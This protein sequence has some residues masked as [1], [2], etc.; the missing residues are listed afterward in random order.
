VREVANSS[1]EDRD[2]DQ[3]QAAARHPL[4]QSGLRQVER[5]RQHAIQDKAQ[6]QA[7]EMEE[8]R[9][10]YDARGYGITRLLVG[11]AH[12]CSYLPGNAPKVRIADRVTT[13]VSFYLLTI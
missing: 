5:Q 3:D 9:S 6:K 4:H 11:R 2:A 1:G 8:W 10:R 12:V 13:R 7:A